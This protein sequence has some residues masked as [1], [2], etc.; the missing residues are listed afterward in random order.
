[1]NCLIDTHCHLD[2]RVYENDLEEVI[3]ES[4]N[5]GV[6]K[7]IIPGAD[8][9]DLPNAVAIAEKYE[10]IY[11]AVGI[12]PYEIQNAHIPSLKELISHPKCVGVGECGL[13]YYRLPP[14]E[15]RKDYKDAQKKAFISQIELSIAFDKPLIVHIREASFDAFEILSRYKEAHGV[16]HCFNADEILLGLSDRFYYGIGGVATFKNAKKIIEILPK[17]PKSRL[18]LE[19]DAPYLSPHPY[20]GERNE[21]MRIPLIA[22][23]LSEVLAMNVDEIA[24]LTTQNAYDLFGSI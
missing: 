7:I 6:K 10:Q 9:K 12:H 11:F 18:L 20:R 13:D 15:E 8:L 23:K 19:T 5:N 14:E 1:M 21:P 17:I 2:S 24:S 22:H 16:L 4:M 3:Q